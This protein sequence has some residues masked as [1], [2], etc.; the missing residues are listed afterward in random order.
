MMMEAHIFKWNRLDES[1]A[2][3][4]I[5]FS[6]C[7]PFICISSIRPSIHLNIIDPTIHPIIHPPNY[8][9]ILPSID[10]YISSSGTLSVGGQC[11]QHRGSPSVSA[12]GQICAVAQVI[13]VNTKGDNSLNWW[14]WLA[15]PL[16]CDSV[17][18][19]AVLW[20]LGLP[21]LAWQLEHRAQ[22]SVTIHSRTLH[23]QPSIYH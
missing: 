4:F 21:G 10:S 19:F 15:W 16:T 13:G 7:Y 6:G 12:I 5:S 9:F 22:W 14:Y 20:L 1:C 11:A 23:L 18:H 17:T 3:S 2:F 8:T